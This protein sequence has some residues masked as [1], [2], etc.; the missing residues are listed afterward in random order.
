MN[1]RRTTILAAA[2]LTVLFAVA[3]TTTALSPQHDAPNSA[4]IG[5]EPLIA[6]R[7][8]HSAI[9]D[10]RFLCLTNPVQWKE[11]WVEHQGDELNRT[12]Q[13]SPICPT[14]DFDRCLVIAVFRGDSW[15]CDGE[16]VHS[17]A[18]RE[19]DVLIRFDSQTYQTMKE[20]NRVTPFGIWVLPR[21]SKP[22]VLEENVQGILGKPPI[23]KEQARF[24]PAA[25]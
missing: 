17:I 19:D 9:A 18:D 3:A 11:L 14:I 15:N 2:A 25:N 7:G 12:V 22:I 16:F 4:A 6:F 23:W 1:R 20:G 21:T 13:G 24:E 10:Q 5:E 8:A